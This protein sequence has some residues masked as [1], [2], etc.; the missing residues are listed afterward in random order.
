MVPQHPLADRDRWRRIERLA[1]DASTRAYTRLT[2]HTGRSW[3]LSEYPAEARAFLGRDLEVL[4]WLADQGLRVPELID[5]DLEAGWSLLED[6]GRNDAARLL[7]AAA[8]EKRREVLDASLTPLVALA[9]I[10]PAQLP[11]WNPPLDGSRL[12][13]ELAGFELWFVRHWRGRRPETWLAD[14]LDG[15]ARQIGGHPKRICHRDYHLNNLF[16]LSDGNVGVI[17]AQD[18]LVGPDTYDAVS[19]LAERD[20]PRLI[21]SALRLDW[22][23]RWAVSTGA[24]P[25]WQ[26]RWPV[27]RLQRGLKVLGT[28][29]RLSVGGSHGYRQWLES[30]ATELVA[31]AEL[32]Q[33]PGR[34]RPILVD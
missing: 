4:S 6:L 23:E 13:W 27:V 32:L 5:R 15:I 14:W 3:I 21:D 20:T 25:G 16:P 11:S 26:Q 17:D 29:A 8:V 19:L 18:I 1:G 31:D 9:H 10:D 28:F 22:L 7:R 30:L 33:L 34:L 2:D 12:R 24:T